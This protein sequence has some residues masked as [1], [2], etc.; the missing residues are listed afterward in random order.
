MSNYFLVR[1]HAKKYFDLT[2]IRVEKVSSEHSLAGSTNISGIDFIYRQPASVSID[3]FESLLTHLWDERVCDL[4][5]SI[6]SLCPA[7]KS[8]QELQNQYHMAQQSGAPEE[9]L[10]LSKSKL[11]EARQAAEQAHEILSVDELIRWSE[12]RGNAT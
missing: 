6:C 8:A 12:S 4:V 3:E 9:L 1:V 10:A 11:D 2:R 7:G 5:Q